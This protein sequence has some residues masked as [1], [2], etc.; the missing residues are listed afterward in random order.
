LPTARAVA[1]AAAEMVVNNPVPP[2]SRR[3]FKSM[4]QELLMVQEYK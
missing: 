4:V 2:E 1:G 3:Y